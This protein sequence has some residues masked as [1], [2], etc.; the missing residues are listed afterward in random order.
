MALKKKA[1]PW[2]GICCE[3]CWFAEEEK[4]RCR[5]GGRNHGRG[6]VK[7]Y[8]RL[9]DYTKDVASELGKAKRLATEAPA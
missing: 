7:A 6:V 5:C 9:D 4:C 1:A 2:V 8:A 3:S